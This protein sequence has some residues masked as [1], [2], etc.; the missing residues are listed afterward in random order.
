[1]ELVWDK[2]IHH[3]E[4]FPLF[5][6]NFHDSCHSLSI[7]LGSEIWAEQWC[8][9]EKKKIL[10]WKHFL[11]SLKWL[12]FVLLQY[13]RL[14]VSIFLSLFEMQIR[15]LRVGAVI[16]IDLC[17]SKATWGVLFFSLS[18]FLRV[19]NS[20]TTALVIT[21]VY[22]GNSCIIILQRWESPID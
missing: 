20:K 16:F 17:T 13:P 7:I 14:S 2:V 9:T 12:Y 11:S 19:N 3:T 15:G 18:V 10:H 8:F 4:P 22:W 1:M 6:L 5:L 21:E